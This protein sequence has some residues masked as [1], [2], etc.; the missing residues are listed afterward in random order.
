[1]HEHH[2][3]SATACCLVACLENSHEEMRA[4]MKLSPLGSLACI[5]F[6]HASRN[7]TSDNPSAFTNSGHKHTQ[8]RNSQCGQRKNVAPAAMGNV[9]IQ[10]QRQKLHVDSSCAASKSTSRSQRIDM[11]F[12]FCSVRS[13]FCLSA[14]L[15]GFVRECAK[16]CS[17]PS[18]FAV[19]TRKNSR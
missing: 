19:T 15:A 5:S 14:A 18:R 8:R 2:V 4:C 13:L 17:I 7:W 3:E 10:I 12:L 9:D 6:S 11:I 1:M 16:Y